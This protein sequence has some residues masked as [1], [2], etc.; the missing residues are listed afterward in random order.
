VG[1][2]VNIHYSADV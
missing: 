1:L 2:L